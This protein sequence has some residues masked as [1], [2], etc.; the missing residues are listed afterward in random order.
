MTH[1]EARV[2]ELT[3]AMQQRGGKAA[4]DPPAVRTRPTRYA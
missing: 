1:L 4:A 2:D 3:R